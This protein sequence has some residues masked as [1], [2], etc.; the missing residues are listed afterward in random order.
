MPYSNAGTRRDELVGSDKREVTNGSNKEYDANARASFITYFWEKMAERGIDRD[1]W[2]PCCNEEKARKELVGGHVVYLEDEGNPDKEFFITQVCNACS[3]MGTTE[4]SYS[5]NAGYL[6]PAP[7]PSGANVRVAL[8]GV[9][10]S[11]CYCRE[12]SSCVFLG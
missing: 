11:P 12:S 1:S 8:D 9:N 10:L 3:T 4:G 6:V 7:C 5:V 2:C